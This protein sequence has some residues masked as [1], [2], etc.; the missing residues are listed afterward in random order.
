MGA[1]GPQIAL[2]VLLVGLIGAAQSLQTPG[3]GYLAEAG[4]NAAT[5]PGYNI[6]IGQ[7]LPQ[8]KVLRNSAEFHVTPTQVT[9]KT[10]TLCFR[11]S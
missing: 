1:Q 4:A 9:V 2:G 3:G 8:L 10:S 7:P 6:P 11:T 5:F